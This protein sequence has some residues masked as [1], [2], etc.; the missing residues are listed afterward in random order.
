[1][2][3][4]MYGLNAHDPSP[5]WLTQA[6]YMLYNHLYYTSL[7]LLV[8][9]NC[10]LNLSYWSA[11]V[12]YGLCTYFFSCTFTFVYNAKHRT[13][14]CT[15]T[16]KYLLNMYWIFTHSHVYFNLNCSLFSKVLNVLTLLVW[17]ISQDFLLR[18]PFR[19]ELQWLK[20]KPVNTFLGF[21][22]FVFLIF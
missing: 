18:R 6:L 21:L 12:G 13:Q 11:T 15:Y 1:M 19:I 4:G 22:C 14:T 17:P 10:A 9:I 8:K 16:E 2:H 7:T 20:F 5:Q 3:C